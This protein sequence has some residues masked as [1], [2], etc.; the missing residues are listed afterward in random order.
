MRFS[1]ILITLVLLPVMMIAHLW[2]YTQN[3]QS[4][5]V[6]E[7]GDGDPD[8]PWRAW[9]HGGCALSGSQRDG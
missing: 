7:A 3:H 8:N 2:D 6:N 1:V 9:W 5:L 4:R